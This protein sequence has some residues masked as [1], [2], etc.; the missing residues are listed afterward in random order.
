MTRAEDRL[1]TTQDIA[2][3]VM[4]LAS[5]KSRWVTAQWISLSGGIT[6]TV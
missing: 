2:D 4:M 1:G 3:G 6:G 5:E